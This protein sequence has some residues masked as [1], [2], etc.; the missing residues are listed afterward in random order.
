L[1]HLVRLFAITLFISTNIW[2][3]VP[4]A[5]GRGRPKGQKSAGKSP[6]TPGAGAA[7]SPHPAIP[8][9]A[10]AGANL[11][12]EPLPPIPD[13]TPIPIPS[14]NLPR[15]GPGNKA[16]KATGGAKKAVGKRLAKVATHKQDGSVKKPHRFRPGTVAL[17]EI[18]KF[19]KSTDLLIRKAPFQRLVREVAQEMKPR[20]ED[21]IRMQGAAIAALQEACES[22]LVNLFK[23][24][25]ICAIHARRVTIMPKDL[26]LA[27][28]LR[29]EQAR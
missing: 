23:D 1:N 28:R 9:L 29:G 13:G 27:R 14:D 7:K 25:N 17:R 8:N 11:A 5:R 18:R 12:T 4:A 16:G 15:R 19:Q 24:I 2:C 3:I 21:A 22:Y 6:R 10:N 26:I 20:D